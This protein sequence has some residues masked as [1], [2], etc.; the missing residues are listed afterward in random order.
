MS[1]Q[2]KNDQV[3]PDFEVV[4]QELVIPESL[5]LKNFFGQ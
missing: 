4:S 1:V 2:I 5:L 3:V